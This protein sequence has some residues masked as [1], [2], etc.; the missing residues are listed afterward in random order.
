MGRKR[1]KE[2]VTDPPRGE[3]VN[4]PIISGVNYEHP[5]SH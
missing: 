2:R 5:Q 4:H 1:L 3:K